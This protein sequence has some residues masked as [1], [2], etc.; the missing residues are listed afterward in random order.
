MSCI[1]DL[2]WRDQGIK[3]KGEGII[4]NWL[5][6]IVWELIAAWSNWVNTERADA[7]KSGAVQFQLL[8]CLKGVK[9]DVSYEKL[10]SIRAMTTPPGSTIPLSIV[11]QAQ[12]FPF[13][14]IDMSTLH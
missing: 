8:S 12:N 1:D 7:A 9:C 3:S 10:S 13:Q 2:F 14:N 11:T 6:G 5:F 4:I